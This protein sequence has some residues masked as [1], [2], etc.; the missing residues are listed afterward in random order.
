MPLLSSLDTLSMFQQSI[1][2]TKPHFKPDV[3]K[4]V[5]DNEAS[6]DDSIMPLEYFATYELE[7]QETI[8]QLNSELDRECG[9]SDDGDE[10]DAF[11]S[12]SLDN[13]KPSDSDSSSSEEPLEASSGLCSLEHKLDGGNEFGDYELSLKNAVLELSSLSEVLVCS[14]VEQDACC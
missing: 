12:V 11:L 2:V 3:F 14:M 13:N 4:A 1:E 7:L 6:D 5:P 10:D 8:L 9:S